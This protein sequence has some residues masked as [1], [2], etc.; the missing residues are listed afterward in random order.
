MKYLLIS[1]SLSN[2]SAK[3]YL[4]RFM[5]VRVIARQIVTFFSETQCRFENH[6]ISLKITKFCKFTSN[7]CSYFHQCALTEQF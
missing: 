4:N 1:Y 5:Y 6:Q 2:I 3:N 7:L